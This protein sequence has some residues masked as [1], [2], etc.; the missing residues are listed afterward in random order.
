MENKKHIEKNEID[1]INMITNEPQNNI[2]F[3]V[4]I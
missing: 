3:N 4:I 2:G 1:N